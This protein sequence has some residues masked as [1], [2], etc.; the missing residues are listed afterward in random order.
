[1]TLCAGDWVQVRSKQEILTSLDA[2]GHLDGMPFMPQMFKWCGK[3]FQV[4]ARAHKT[5]DTVTGAKTG[6]W[7]GRRL[8]NAVHLDLRCDGEAYGGCQAA[9]L[10]FWKDAWLRPID[11]QDSASAERGPTPI[12]TLAGCTEQAVW[13]ATKSRNQIAEKG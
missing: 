1:M 11:R 12:R 8:P 6:Q 13:D 5:C 7:L 4:L 3:R 2:N 9:C 10:I